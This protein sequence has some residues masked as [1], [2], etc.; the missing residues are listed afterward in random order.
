LC[1]CEE[2]NENGLASGTN[3]KC[4]NAVEHKIE[5]V[6]ENEDSDALR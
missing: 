6:Q 3:I 1:L 4:D 5:R 2:E